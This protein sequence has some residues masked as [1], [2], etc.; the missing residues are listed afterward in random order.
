MS[1][2]TYKIEVSHDPHSPVLPYDAKVC[3]VSDGEHVVTRWGTTAIEAT[4]AA[5]AW[6][7]AEHSPAEPSTTLYASESGD[8]IGQP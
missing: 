6:I 2:P 8:L 3:R 4:K 7:V 1:E 5:Q